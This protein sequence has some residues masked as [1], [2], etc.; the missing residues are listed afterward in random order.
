[1]ENLVFEEEG[2]L[3][4]NDNRKYEKNWKKLGTR[5]TSKKSKEN[6]L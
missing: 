6:T 1:M 3:N 2:L 4:L 5:Y